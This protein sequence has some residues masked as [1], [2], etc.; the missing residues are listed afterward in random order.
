LRNIKG[1][2]FEPQNL[3]FQE[4]GINCETCHGPSTQHIAEMTQREF[5]LAN[6][7]DP[8]VNFHGAGN[9]DF[10]AICS[11]CHMQ[12]AIR[13]PGPHGELN[14]SSSSEFFMRSQR[15]PFG[16]FSRK[17][18]YKDGRFR[19]TTFIVEALERSQ[20]F[21][22]GQVSCGN[23]HDPHGH[24][25]NRDT[26]TSNPASLR[27]P[28]QPDRACT[29]CHKQFQDA[30]NLT[31]H[32]HHRADSE[33]RRCVS[34]HMPRIM[35]ALLFRARTHQ[36]DDVPNADMTQRFGQQESPN[37]CLLCHE[38]KNAEWVKQQLQSWLPAGR[39]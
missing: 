34:C 3:E 39:R 36:I 1:G 23:C 38:K 19:Q 15:I 7:L 10:V 14:Y 33:G 18:F 16:E 37:A 31:A 27:F 4:P 6:P 20:C 32:T 17:G 11:Q 21:K 9:R 13:T 22:K 29:D 25:S 24:V 5:Y 28:D 8:P 30:S 2:G 26:S 35:D 12:S